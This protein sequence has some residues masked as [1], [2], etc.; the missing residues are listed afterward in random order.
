MCNTG[1]KYNL[2]SLQY[3]LI[4]KR[5]FCLPFSVQAAHKFI[6]ELF[7]QNTKHNTYNDAKIY[8]IC[9]HY[10][11]SVWEL[12]DSY[13]ITNFLPYKWVLDKAYFAKAAY[14]AVSNSTNPKPRCCPFIFL[15]NF[16]LFIEPKCL[17]TYFTSFLVAW[18]A[19]FFTISFV[20][21]AYYLLIF[22]FSSLIF[23]YFWLSTFFLETDNIRRCPSK[24]WLCNFLIT[25]KAC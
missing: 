7:K 20:E 16:I 1:Y 12:P 2:H 14:W 13:S 6:I 19:M 3:L 15:G 5:M 11:F 18:K 25:F 24:I 9:S 22:Y 17:N 23:S 21:I 4:N 10:L 8:I